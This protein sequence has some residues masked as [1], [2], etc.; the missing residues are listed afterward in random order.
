MSINLKNLEYGTVTGRFLVELAD[1]ADADLKPDMYPA[2]GYVVFTPGTNFASVKEAEPDPAIIFPQPVIGV[3]DSQGYLCTAS[4]NSVNNVYAKTVNGDY[5]PTRRGVSLQASS[6]TSL[7]PHSWSWRV[8]FHFKYHNKKIDFKGFNF[9]LDAD[10]VVDLSVAKPVSEKPGE[11]TIVGPRGPRGEKGDAGEPNSLSIGK[12]ESLPT[13]ST[14]KASISG[15]SPNQTLN[16]SLPAGPVGPSGGPIPT[17]GRGGQTL[18]K[19]ASG[20][21][22]WVPLRTGSVDNCFP[23]GSLEFQNTSGFRDGYFE[24]RTDDKPDGFAGAVWLTEGQKLSSYDGEHVIGLSALEPGATY[25]FEVWLKANKPDSVIYMEVRDSATSTHAFWWTSVE[26]GGAQYHYPIGQLKVPTTWTKF[27][28]RNVPDPYSA[29]SGY[30]GAIYFNHPAGST[31]DALIGIAGLKMKKVITEDQLDISSSIGATP[32]TFVKRNSK[33][34]SS[35]T[36]VS[37]TR[38]PTLASH[39]TTRKYVDDKIKND[40]GAQVDLISK[41]R[42]PLYVAHRGGCNVYPEE[43]MEGFIASAEDGFYPEMDIQFTKDNVPVCHHDSTMNRTVIGF[44]G[45]VSGITSKDWAKARIRPKIDGGNTAR[46]VFFE[47]VLDRL[48]GKTVLIPEIKSDATD[49]QLKIVFD[50]I[51]ERKLEKSVIIQSFN[52]E[53]AK[54]IHSAGFTALYLM[55]NTINVAT[56]TIKS[57]GI[58]YLGVSKNMT[59][60]NIS[61]LKSETGAYIMPYTVNRKTEMDALSGSSIDGVFTDDPWFISGSMNASS[62]GWW[63]KGIGWPSLDVQTRV[64]GENR[65]SKDLNFIRLRGG[66][67]HVPRDEK[68]GATH[69]ALDHLIG[70]DGLIDRPLTLNARFVFHRRAHADIS[71]VGFT[72]IKNT[73]DPYSDFFDGAKANQ[74]GYTFAVRRNGEAAIWNF[75]VGKAAVQIKRNTSFWSGVASDR[76]AEMS[77]TLDFASGGWMGLYSSEASQNVSITDPSISGPFRAYLRVVGVEASIYDVN[78]SEYVNDS[79]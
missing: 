66:G 43:S 14:P 60:S 8:D 29:N 3:L 34:E 48:G 59:S 75:P 21:T 72:L 19:S 11:Y 7:N 10:Q 23:N 2:Q 17:G 73:D 1:S 38:E 30:L 76:M 25:E 57:S 63:T 6:D 71:N 77:L 18:E 61:K 51:K 79:L 36:S 42:Y 46:A 65:I 50:M 5:V 69:I 53:T 58:K 16:L 28:S 33:G 54:K 44:T 39:V 26:G 62:T 24:W 32:S 55:S 27:R 45:P 9:T 35:F 12:V 40:A 49:A 68:N 56:S 15:E 22:D 52:W 74:S 37:L 31:Q 78:V 13:G 20:S 67:I 47:D 64:N 41:L 70:G 4:F